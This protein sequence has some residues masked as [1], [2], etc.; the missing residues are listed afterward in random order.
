MSCHHLCF[1]LLKERVFLVMKPDMTVIGP[2]SCLLGDFF[3]AIRTGGTTF[4]GIFATLGNQK[5]L[6]SSRQTTRD[7][8]Q[9]TC[10]L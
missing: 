1:H 5:A 2:M 7:S 4:T 10:T 6:K 8:S 3:S 9:P